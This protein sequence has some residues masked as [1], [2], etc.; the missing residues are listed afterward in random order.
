MRRFP[1]KVNNIIGG[2]G[3]QKSFY[4]ALLTLLAH[5]HQMSVETIPDHAKFLV[6]QQD[7]ETL[8]NQY[9]YQIA[10]QQYQMLSLLDGQVHFLMNVLFRNCFITTSTI[11]KISVT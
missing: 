4:T 9:Q 3:T 7:M 6:W 2:P 1:T 5:R 10:H 11:Q 8:K